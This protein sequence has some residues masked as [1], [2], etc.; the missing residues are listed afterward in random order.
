MRVVTKVPPT[1]FVVANYVLTAL[2]F[3]KSLSLHFSVF[4]TDFCWTTSDNGCLK[5]VVLGG[6]NTSRIWNLLKKNWIQATKKCCLK[7]F[8]TYKR[9]RYLEATLIT[10]THIPFSMLR[11]NIR[12]WQPGSACHYVACDAMK[13]RTIC[14]STFYHVHMFVALLQCR[15]VLSFQA[16][17]LY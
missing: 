17:V 5:Q 16:H 15:L 13:L 1:G 3:A 6:P 8:C 11:T 12:G 4:P 7:R 10:V 2:E 9:Y 14:G